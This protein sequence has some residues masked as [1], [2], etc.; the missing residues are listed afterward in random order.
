MLT[1]KGLCRSS[2]ALGRKGTK[3]P[4][5][6]LNPM[7]LSRISVVGTP[8]MNRPRSD[9]FDEDLTIAALDLQPPQVTSSGELPSQV[10]RE[11]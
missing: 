1:V 6:D 10:D 2:T 4:D 7:E 8:M 5:R 11:T 3:T 9:A